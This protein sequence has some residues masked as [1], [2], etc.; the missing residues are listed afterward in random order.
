VPRGR[1]LTT[2]KVGQ[3]YVPVNLS[4]DDLRG[5]RVIADLENISLGDLVALGIRSKYGEAL[6]KL[7]GVKREIFLSAT[8]DKSSN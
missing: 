1:K 8:E 2:M 6:K 7:Q 3:R 5:I 4:D